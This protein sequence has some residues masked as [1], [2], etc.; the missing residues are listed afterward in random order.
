MAAFN[1]PNSPSTND[2][3]T[4]NGVTYKWNGTVWKRQNASYTDST[5][6]N[7]TGIAT[8]AGAVS[9]G[10]TL[11][12][13]DVKN[14]DSVGIVT[15]REGIFLPD[16][17]T[18]K[19]GNTSASPDFTI[20]HN[21][22]NSVINNT[23]G[24]LLFQNNGSS[25]AWINNNGVIYT[26]NDLFVQTANGNNILLDKSDNLLRFGDN[27]LARFGNDDDLEMYH[28]GSTGYIKNTTGT[29]YIQDDSNIIIGSVTGSETGAKYIKDG[30]YELYHN[31]I[32]KLATD[33]DGIR[34]GSG[35]GDNTIID[36]HNASYDNG[37]IQ[38]Y[39]GSIHLKTGSSN[40][41]R[42][43]QVSTAGSER[44]RIASTGFVGIGTITP[45]RKL[46]VE[47]DNA[48]IVL[49]QSTRA[50][51]SYVNYKV[52]AN[53]AELGMIG[54]GAAIL[55]GGADAGDFG[56]RS[57]GDLCFSSGGHAERLRIS[58]GGLLLLGTTDT[59]FSS[60]YTN[61]TIGNTSTNNTGLTIASSA[62]NGFSRI[63]FADA[64]SSSGRYAG[65]IAYDHSSDSLKIATGNVGS[66][67]FVMESDGDLKISSGAADTNY[68]WIRGWQSSTGD[69]IISADHSATGSGDK[70]N[71]I[72]KSRGSE[73]LRIQYDGK[74]SIDEGV[75]A[76]LTPSQTTAATIGGGNMSGGSSWFNHTNGADYYGVDG[77]HKLT[78]G[79]TYGKITARNV[80][81]VINSDATAG[82][83][84]FLI[85]K[86]VGGTLGNS[87][88]K[89][90]NV[91]GWKLKWPT[92]LAAG[93]TTTLYMR[94]AVESFG[95]PTVPDSGDYYI[96]WFFSSSQDMG[97]RGSS[98]FV[99]STSGGKVYYHNPSSDLSNPGQHIPSHNDSWDGTMTGQKI[100]FRYETLPV[101]DLTGTVLKS[102][103][104]V[105]PIMQGTP[106]YD[107][108]PMTGG[109]LV[110][111]VEWD[112]NTASIE[113]S[114]AS[115][116]DSAY[117]IHY[118]L[119][120][121]PGW[122]QTRFQFM[123]A[124][125]TVFG[126]SDHYISHCEWCSAGD[127]DPT[128]N[129]NSNGSAGQAGSI[130]LSGN[131]ASYGHAGY[132]WVIPSNIRHN[133]SSTL[134]NNW[135][136]G[137][138]GQDEINHF[139]VRGLSYLTQGQSASQCYREQGGGQTRFGGYNVSGFRIYGCNS[140]SNNG[141]ASDGSH[142]GWV[143]I[144]RY[145]RG[146]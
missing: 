61:M 41:D 142:N 129:S 18:I 48:E 96:A 53:G 75:T 106:T 131:G 5:N 126:D 113:Y 72:F 145:K 133:F 122:Y 109:S 117:L 9:V 97:T 135:Q 78:N 1:F 25:S 49:Y 52:G 50:A 28:T 98:W 70:S 51:G 63:H 103:L 60:G 68:G 125:K 94:D 12:Y 39:N 69:M 10:G 2:L 138:V 130:W 104:L 8:F 22:T 57:A 43:F 132:V 93:A 38:Y 119:T 88:W 47:D 116:T 86:T 66:A 105:D 11:T 100:H 20:Q 143:A 45:L 123:N 114:S 120:G 80:N 33:L 23:T 64:N 144:Y 90:E 115:F 13:E 37:L 77:D 21:G 30:A 27:V 19:I 134:T 3:H 73:K 146:V 141:P 26:N 74:L 95:S 127:T 71:L 40:G 108:H 140:S 46:H 16:S 124:D 118:N 121:N 62:S 36:L 32:L 84:Y 6:L 31:N 15:A 81:A 89:L 112:S 17:K 55:S 101:A 99:D 139:Y 110:K 54:S 42:L 7:V 65:W 4:E 83:V 85:A 128:T 35:G 136:A 111:W 82:H 87:N 76:L 92:S 29:L 67:R 58:S 34:I 79:V 14:V 24:S 102:P 137:S 107:G 56:I 91:A 44:L 59:G